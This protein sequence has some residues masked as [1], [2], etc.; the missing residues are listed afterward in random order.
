[1]RSF[2]K[3]N[4]QL[5]AVLKQGTSPGKLAVCVSGATALGL[6]PV[7]GSTTL[8]VTLFS[9]SFRLNLP[10]AQLVNFLVY[11]L[12]IILLIPFMQAGQSLFGNG[13]FEFTLTQIYAILENDLWNGILQLWDVTMLAIFAWIVIVPLSTIIL[14]FVLRYIFQLMQKTITREKSLESR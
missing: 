14:F 6:F 3:L 2:K 9:I 7:L 13:E 1:M 8:L 12:Q 11:P 4:K 10:A 5:V